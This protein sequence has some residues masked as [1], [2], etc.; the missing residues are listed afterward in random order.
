[1]FFS[2]SEF[3]DKANNVTPMAIN[4]NMEI[5]LLLTDVGVA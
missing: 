3:C 1:L 5:C 4:L 2:D